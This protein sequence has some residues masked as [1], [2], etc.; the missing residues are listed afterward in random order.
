MPNLQSYDNVSGAARVSI[1]VGNGKTTPW[2]TLESSFNLVCE[3][4]T[5]E[6][7]K[8][9]REE[10]WKETQEDLQKQIEETVASLNCQIGG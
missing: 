2:I 10:G 6:A 5:K 7:R 9:K 3:D 4:N 8:S 1:P